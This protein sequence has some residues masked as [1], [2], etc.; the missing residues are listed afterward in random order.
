MENIFIISFIISVIFT[1]MKIL[2]MKFLESEHKKPLKY[3]I[4]DSLLVYF[5]VIV[6]DFIIEQISPTINKIVQTNS[7][8]SA[9]LS[10]P[11]F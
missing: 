1:L 3:L 5:S 7:Q 8:P 6:G 10:E 11:S 9:F 4:R 2:E